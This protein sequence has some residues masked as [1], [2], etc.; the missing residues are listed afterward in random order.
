MNYEPRRPPNAGK[1]R[2]KGVVNKTTADVRA[3]IA[4]IAESKAHL[5]EGWLSRVAKEDPGRAV[6]LYLRL[7]EYHIPKLSRAEVTGAG[8]GGLQVSV[9]IVDPTRRGAA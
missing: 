2:R 4:K 3:A 9:T 7:I 5:V 8:G 6:D 1:G